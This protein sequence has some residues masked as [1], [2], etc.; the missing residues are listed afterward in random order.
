M[1]SP[2][3]HDRQVVPLIRPSAGTPPPPQADFYEAEPESGVQL[4]EIFAALR[5]RLWLLLAV[6]AAT[7]GVTAYLVHTEVPQYRATA[8]LRFKDQRA[9]LTGGIEARAAE[10]VVG[11]Q[12]D[13][14][15]SQVQL[16]RSRGV[17]AEVVRAEG[18][19]LRVLEG[20]LSRDALSEVV[21]QPDAPPDTLQLAFS[22][23]GVTARARGRQGTA[24]YGQPVQ[25]PGVRF[26]VVRAPGVESA[27]LQV[28]DE[29]RAIQRV[30]NGLR[31]TP[32]ERTDVLDL[33]YT[34]PDRHLARA[35]ANTTAAAFQAMNVR[36]SQDQSRRRRIFIEEQLRQADS[37]LAQAQLALTGF[38]ER[39]QVFSSR[40]KIAAQQ[41]GLSDLE[42]RREEMEADR[43]M[44]Q[45][46][47]NALSRPQAQAG[48]QRVRTLVSSPGIAS[49]PVVS[50]LYAQLVQYEMARDTLTAGEWGSTGSNPDVAR[51]NT[52]IASTEARLIDAA[53]SHVAALDARIAAM[54]G[55][56]ARNEVKIGALPSVEAEEV[57]LTEQVETVRAMA[58]LLRQEHQRARIAEAVEAGQVEIVDLAALPADPIPQ[59]RNAK[60]LLGLMLGIM[61]GGG[62]VFVLEHL[63]TTI[64][65][66]EDLEQ[67][68]QMPALGLIPRLGGVGGQGRGIL[69]RLP[70]RGPRKGSSEARRGAD[71]VTVAD[72]RSPG[73]EAFR[74]LRTN[75]IFS[76]AVHKLRTLVLTSASPGEGK[77]TTTANL[78]V[79]FAQQGLRVLLVDCDLRRAR[80]HHIFSLPQEPGFT[81]LVMGRTDQAQACQPSGIEGLWVLTAGTLPPNPAEL[82]GSDA[83]A[84][85]FEHLA[86][87]FDLVLVDTPPL[88]AASD[89]AV[90]GSRADGMVV[91]VRAGSTDRAA[92]QRVVQQLNGLGARVVGA[93]LNDPDD[94]SPRLGYSYAYYSS[95]APAAS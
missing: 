14:M 48:G 42:L 56:M 16:L 83:T 3:V 72:P 55:M 1:G 64:R 86:R 35:V 30:L 57:R 50:Q 51:L 67:A 11:R 18:L 24:P 59:G 12:N 27:A 65:R 17:A 36:A 66:K 49:N 29:E 71:L 46:L 60:L 90:V 53:R 74:T 81:E 54:D 41:T 52:L 87:D 2:V 22:A 62:L 8:V 6:A 40:D 68:L 9:A 4:K 39:E 92:A 44:Y 75:L 61:L 95:Y 63:N 28:V 93:V 31:A 58:D 77:S 5:R 37:T 34:D 38:R 23:T 13:P 15:L 43:R 70:F 84:R 69:A 7:F 82:L 25:L 47:L 88:L 79:A 80:A 21:V 20:G 78:A 94:A 73:A 32:R 85:T 89:A 91:V 76:Q 33:E 26:T 19:R 45:A 10:Q